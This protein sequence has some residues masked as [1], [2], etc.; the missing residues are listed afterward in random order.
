MLK[1]KYLLLLL[2]FVQSFCASQL[3]N[4]ISPQGPLHHDPLFVWY[5]LGWFFWGGVGGVGGE[6]GGVFLFG[7]FL[8]IMGSLLSLL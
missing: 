3:C 8:V 6:V 5:F 7:F 4:A 1:D 2:T